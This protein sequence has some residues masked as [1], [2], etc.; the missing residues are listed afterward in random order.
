MTTPRSPHEDDDFRQLAGAFD[1]PIAPSPRFAEGLKA[2]LEQE[3]FAQKA[4]TVPVRPVSE[5]TARAGS[6]PMMG[7]RRWLDV[8]IAAALIVAML[9]GTLWYAVNRI[10]DG[11]PVRPQATRYAAQPLSSTP[12]AVDEEVATGDP[13]NAMAFPAGFDPIAELDTVT[14][15]NAPAQPVY[16]AIGGNTLVVSGMAPEWPDLGGPVLAA[17]DLTSGSLLWTTQLTAYGS[18]HISGDRIVGVFAEHGEAEF[19]MMSLSLREG[20]TVWRGEDLIVYGDEPMMIAIPP[21]MSIRPVVFDDAV[22]Y[23]DPVGTISALDAASGELLW[24]LSLEQSIGVA[25]P[26]NAISVVGDERY[27]YA[28]DHENAMRK[29]DRAT[30]EVVDRFPIADRPRSRFDIELHL[31]GDAV[32][33]VSHPMPGIEDVAFVDVLSTGDGGTLWSHRLGAGGA[34]ITITEQVI[35]IPRSVGAAEIE[36]GSDLTEPGAYVSFF[37]LETGET[38][39][40]YGPSDWGYSTVSSSG[41]VVCINEGM[42]ITCSDFESD[43]PQFIALPFSP[44]YRSISPLLFWNDAAIVLTEGDGVVLLQP[45]ETQPQQAAGPLPGDPGNT[46]AYTETIDLSRTYT[47]ETFGG[48]ELGASEML[49]VGDDL[50]FVGGALT[51][52]TNLSIANPTLMSRDIATGEHNWTFRKPGVE[53]WPQ[54]IATDGE[55]VY[56]VLF[57]PNQPMTYRLI[58]LDGDT[59]EVRWEIDE[60]HL[61]AEVEPGERYST[62][63]LV[64]VGDLVL[65]PYGPEI[66]LALDMETGEPVWTLAPGEGESLYPE[67]AYLGGS[68]VVANSET[69]FRGLPDGSVEEIDLGSGTVRS[70]FT[71]PQDQE[72]VTHMTLHLQGDYMVIKREIMPDTGSIRYTLDVHNIITRQGGWTMGTTSNLGAVVVTPDLLVVNEITHREPTWIEQVL[73]FVN[74]PMPRTHVLGFDLP[75]GDEVE[76][77]VD[78]E[79]SFDFPPTLGAAGSIVCVATK[80]VRCVDRDGN[81]MVVEG[82]EVEDYIPHNPPVYW[83]GQIIIGNGMGPLTIAKPGP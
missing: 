31:K 2:Q 7:R 1:R 67:D 25:G 48:S 75:T 8:A 47:A 24:S 79:E 20:T 45:K 70:M 37:D 52:A 59:G 65:V 50:V 27:L 22:Y 26:Q 13:G 28:V 68:P 10:G 36:A 23:A 14:L 60:L 56:A 51:D 73:P 57:N 76:L 3:A 44:G 69:A 19:A 12:I 9:G 32:V 42:A 4:N 58:A 66:L 34:F 53:L 64:V 72:L 5:R 82:Y 40:L 39:A 15:D 6:A 49:V 33:A 38:F 29:I 77:L 78:G 55:D 71:G 43:D 61:L 35:A 18:F 41:D 17:I 74:S 21:S 80:T 54:Q 11:S 83:E 63:D 81:E 62:A 46:N 30:G 16:A